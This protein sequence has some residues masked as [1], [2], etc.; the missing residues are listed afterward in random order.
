[1]DQE[2]T[3]KFIA[4]CR[5]KKNLTQNELA[6]LLGISK[7]AVSK[8]ERGLCLMDMSL[9]KPLC[10]IL[11]ISINEL[12]SG[13]LLKKDE[14]Q[15]KSEE[16]IVKTIE[17]TNKKINH[18]NNII[19]III[20]SFILFI[21]SIITLFIIDIHRM[22]NNKPIFFSTWGFDYY[23]PV[24]L[25]EELIYQAIETYLINQEENN[26]YNNMKTFISMKTYLI[27]ESSE[28][29]TKVYAWIV[30]STYYKENND[31]IEY[32]GSSI[33]YKFTLKKQNNTYKV[34][35]HQIPRDGSYYQDDMIDIFPKSVLKQINKV[36][37]DGTIEK[38]L[39]DI[40]RQKNNYY[41]Q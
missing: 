24:N 27:D 12:L 41:N 31:I 22:K 23:P 3:G 36:H 14:Y 32:G 34:I 16:N 18:K 11:N 35:K 25:N 19:K 40:D 9:L 33:P 30:E 28:D 29:I 2:K 37:Q 39:F 26:K 38:L 20:T 8:W 15:I 21:L 7:N 10:N 5:K 13:D 17:Y 4:T 6:E 1:M